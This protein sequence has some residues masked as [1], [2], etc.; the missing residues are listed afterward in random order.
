MRRSAIPPAKLRMIAKILT[1]NCAGL[2][3]MFPDGRE[4]ATLRQT[5][6]EGFPPCHSA[7]GGPGGEGRGVVL[8]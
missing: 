4:V 3:D 8:A 2:V 5:P 7:Q 6:L 1:I